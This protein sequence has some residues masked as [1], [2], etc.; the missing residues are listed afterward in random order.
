MREFTTAVV[1]VTTT[2]FGATAA[3]GGPPGHDDRR[4]VSAQQYRILTRQCR[5]AD[6]AQARSDCRAEVQRDYRIGERAPDLDCRTYSGVTVCGKL[7]LSERERRCVRDSVAKGLTYR[8]AEVE[9]YAF[10]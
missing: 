7:K 8:R 6:T 9:C 3:G 2:M 5:Y 10:L 1:L 4:Q